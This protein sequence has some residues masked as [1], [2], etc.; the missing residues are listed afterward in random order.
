MGLINQ[1]NAQYY[2]GTQVLPVSTAYPAPYN[3]T[4]NIPLSLGSN[5][6]I[7]TPPLPTTSPPDYTETNFFLETSPTVNGPW[8]IYDG[9]DPNTSAGSNGSVGPTGIGGAFDLNN[10][11]ITF[12]YPYQSPPQN[13]SVDPTWFIR[14]RLKELNYNNYAYV[15]LNDIINNFK[16]GYVGNGKLIPKVERTDILFHAKRGLL[17]FT[18]KLMDSEFVKHFLLQFME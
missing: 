12:K 4:F 13:Y 16:V 1:T 14:V 3:F 6:N 9:V 7:W 2:T 15:T 11:I 8:T 5:I 17:Y 10:N 18:M